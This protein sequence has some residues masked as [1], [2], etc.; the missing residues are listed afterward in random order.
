M[1]EDEVCPILESFGFE[2]DGN[3]DPK[4]FFCPGGKTAKMPSMSLPEIRVF[5][6]ENASWHPE[7]RRPNIGKDAREYFSLRLW[8]ATAQDKL[9][10]YSVAS[11][12]QGISPSSAAARS[13]IALCSSATATSI[14]HRSAN[15]LQGS[16]AA[17]PNNS[18]S[19]HHGTAVAM[20]RN[21]RET[22]SQNI[23]GATLLRGAADDR[24]SNQTANGQSLTTAIRRVSISPGQHDGVA[25]QTNAQ[26]VVEVQTASLCYRDKEDY[27]FE[28]FDTMTPKERQ[29]LKKAFNCWGTT[30]RSV[31]GSFSF[32]KASSTNAE[33]MKA[34]RVIHDSLSS[35]ERECLEASLDMMEYW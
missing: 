10:T 8:A 27:I 28:I 23:F 9:P 29:V 6:R 20:R 7:K 1:L 34:T 31:D 24:Q 5:I 15:Y 25:S 26:A 14:S 18:S 30:H 21:M 11:E 3:E 16:A 22:S 35:K 4:R 33:K 13:S 12:H 32:D 2:R 19:L 17:E